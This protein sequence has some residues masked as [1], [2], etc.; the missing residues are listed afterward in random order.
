MNKHKTIFQFACDIRAEFRVPVFP[1]L[2]SQ[3]ETGKWNKQPLVKWS[4]V[5]GDPSDVSWNGA[6]AVGVPMGLRSGL[7]AI[8]LDDYKPGAQAAR[9]VEE[10]RL[11]LTRTHQTA[12]GGRHL[13]YRLPNGIDCGNHAPCVEG[14]DI[15]GSGGFIVWADIDRHYSVLDDRAPEEL[16][17]AVCTQLLALKTSHGGRID[18]KALPSYHYVS[19]ADLDNKLYKLLRH[20]QGAHLKER[21]QGSTKD[22][23]DKSASGMDMSV[24]ALLARHKF[25]FDEIVQTLLTRFP[26]GV[27][28]RDGWTDKTERSAK[29]CAFRATEQ[30][31]RSLEIRKRA[32]DECL[33]ERRAK[34]S[35]LSVY[36]EGTGQ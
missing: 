31:R 8:D 33:A 26:H 25:S 3:S 21:F 18:D 23:T 4:Q 28:A 11:P 2:I 27:A 29:R 24:A 35:R 17:D 12:S 1:V 6:N 19:E 36:K 20:P 16:P 14:L 15:R 22:L 13:I 7:I 30:R 9:W 10:Q 5:S 34:F 32:M